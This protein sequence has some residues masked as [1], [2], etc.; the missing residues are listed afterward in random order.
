M[1]GFRRGK[2]KSATQ[3]E[4]D[5]TLFTPCRPPLSSRVITGI[6]SVIF[7]SCFFFFFPLLFS[8]YPFSSSVFLFLPLKELGS[9]SMREFVLLQ[10]LRVLVPQMFLIIIHVVLW[11]F[12]ITTQIIHRATSIWFQFSHTM[13]ALFHPVNGVFCG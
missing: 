2:E 4:G 6:R 1:E 9:F 10:C 7:H 3:V 5:I 13:H 12:S 8:F 11:P